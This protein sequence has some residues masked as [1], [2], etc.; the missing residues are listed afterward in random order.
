ME[1]TRH[2]DLYIV[3]GG[4]NKASLDINAGTILI[5]TR[6]FPNWWYRFWYKVLLGWIW[7]RIGD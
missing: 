1:D 2:V 6:K 3:Q 4:E 7:K 5:H